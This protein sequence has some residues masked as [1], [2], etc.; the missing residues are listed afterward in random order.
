MI[1]V[2]AA[3]VREEI[4]QPQFVAGFSIFEEGNHLHCLAT[5]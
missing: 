5:L 2:A 3:Q 1:V 4:A